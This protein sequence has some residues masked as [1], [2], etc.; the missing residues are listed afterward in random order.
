MSTEGLRDMR[1]LITGGTGSIGSALVEEV[2]RLGA[3]EI[4]VL[5]RHEHTLGTNRSSGGTDVH[6]VEADIADARKVAEAVQG[7]DVI[8]HLAALK[9]VAACEA[10]PDA[11]LRTNVLGSTNLLA[12]ARKDP[13]VLRLIAVSS[14]KACAPLGVLGKTKAMMERIVKQ[15]AAESTRSF[16]S[17]RLGSVWGASRSVLARWQE[18]A[19]REGWIDVTNPEMTRFILTQR[20]AIGRLVALSSRPFTGEVVA[21]RMRSY[22][23]GDLAAVFARE[24][25]A[26]V[27]V[28]GA[29]P[30]EKLHEDLVSMDE[31]PAARD[32]GDLIVIDG[33]AGPGIDP[34]TSADADHFSEMELGEL[35]RAS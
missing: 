16:G 11:A 21:P 1:V 25:G 6:F 29:R 23:L 20:E 35:V 8:F 9:D 17:V 34:F 26:A 12:A 13:G 30:G 22:R 24:S 3:R 14:D 31:A 19:T 5:A 15:T 4:R 10:N 2:R 32:E 28:V 18:S 27:R 33:Q 7:V